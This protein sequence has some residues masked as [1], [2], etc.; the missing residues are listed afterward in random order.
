MQILIMFQWVVISIAVIPNL[1]LGLK[2][3]ALKSVYFFVI[4]IMLAFFILAIISDLSLYSLFKP[5]EI[6]KT[7]NE[8]NLLDSLEFDFS[9]IDYLVTLGD[10]FYKLI[11]FFTLFFIIRWLINYVF[12]GL[13]WEFKFKQK[14]KAKK[15]YKSIRNRL[16]G[17]FLGAIKGFILAIIFLSPFMSLFSSINNLNLEAELTYQNYSYENLKTNSGF[18]KY[19]DQIFDYAFVTEFQSGRSLNLREEFKIFFECLT[20]LRNEGYLDSNFEF[21]DSIDLKID[22]IH[23][24]LIKLKNSNLVLSLLEISSQMLIDGFFDE[25]INIEMG[26]FLTDDAK[27][28]IS[29][30]DWEKE[31]ILYTSILENTEGFETFQN[32]N[33]VIE[34]FVVDGE[35]SDENISFFSNILIKFFETE[36]FNFSGH[37]IDSYLNYETDQSEI[38]NILKEIFEDEEVDFKISNEIESFISLIHQVNEFTSISE[39]MSLINEFDLQKFYEIGYDFGSLSEQNFNDLVI[40]IK[41]LQMIDFLDKELLDALIDEYQIA[42]VIIPE[43]FDIDK[44]ID[45]TFNLLRVVSKYLYQ[46]S[47]V[48]VMNAEE[49]DFLELIV[50]NDFSSAIL[51]DGIYDSDLIVPYFSKTLELSNDSI[52]NGINLLPEELYQIEN[53]DDFWINEY[54]ATIRMLIAVLQDVTEDKELSYNNLSNMFNLEFDTILSV[55]ETLSDNELFDSKIIHNI[56][57]KFL[58]SDEFNSMI[59]EFIP[60]EMSEYFTDLS[61]NPSESLMDNDDVLG[62]IFSKDNLV[63]F[64]DAISVISIEEDK[65]ID[66]INLVTGMIDRF[67]NE[68]SSKDD[69]ERFLNSKYL[70]RLISRILTADGIINLISENSFNASIFLDK[71]PDNS[72]SEVEGITYL[73][74]NE[75]RRLIVSLKALNISDLK[76]ISFDLDTISNYSNDQIMLILESDYFYNLVSLIFLNQSLFSIPNIVIHEEG[77]YSNYINKEEIVAIVQSLS[78]LNQKEDI[79]SL[80][81]YDVKQVLSKGSITILKLI[82][83][84]VDNLTTVPIEAKDN[85]GTIKIEEI[86]QLLDFV[87]YM[88]NGNENSSLSSI[89]ISSISAS[90]DLLTEYINNYDSRLIEYLINKTILDAIEVPGS[91]INTVDYSY[92]YIIESE[93]IKLISSLNILGVESI[94]NSFSV[95]AISIGDLGN[96]IQEDSVIINK[97]ISDTVDNLTTVPIEAKDNQ[98]TIKIEEIIQ[99]LDF[100]I[101]MNNGNE[102]SSLS[103]INISSISASVDLLTEYINNYD[104]RLIEYL[105]NKTILDAIEVPGSVINTV[106][107]SYNYII[108]SELIKLISSLNI[109]GVESIENSFSVDAISIGDLGN[110]IQEDSVIINSY[111]SSLIKD[112]IEVPIGS[113]D[114]ENIIFKSELLNVYQIILII[115]D[116]NMNLVLSDAINDINSNSIDSVKMKNILDLNSLIG[117]RIVS[118]GIIETNLASSE[119]FANAGDFNY[120]ESSLDK[121]IKISEM[122]NIADALYI[123]DISNLSEIASLDYESLNALTDEE[124][125]II[126]DVSGTNTFMYYV[127]SDQ[128]VTDE[129]IFAYNL[130][131]NPDIQ[132]TN[133]RLSKQDL[134]TLILSFE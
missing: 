130:F 88:N 133:G 126:L 21:S 49:F 34:N 87:I 111:I 106:D 41:N 26:T 52:I 118:K 121:N 115:K 65:E 97:L 86:I 47:T 12:F 83:D 56:F 23:D 48:P 110:V 119:H 39:L 38:F 20:I 78:V 31:L 30:L 90:V 3:G 42:N 43:S 32:I 84:T 80:T 2:R 114:N 85:Q 134:K 14:E 108:E 98:G 70:S 64:L 9:S 92:N 28:Y 69:L 75:I 99:L 109:L 18:Q 116:N 72:K 117:Y 19:Y 112:S 8:T 71:L 100:V 53:N 125:D 124:V 45:F 127:I 5:E 103:S 122:Y 132:K 102:N 67:S 76:N 73:N 40:N 101:Y 66:I 58:S 54:N 33:D 16:T 7:I 81:L 37:F 63:D 91:V 60:A 68:N 95:D 79:E 11:V 104:S 51:Q 10:I 89:N 61:F 4:N 128:V 123:L 131:N 93:L 44:E 129:L 24:I 82:S 77:E 13:I 94:E 105:I 15:R 6:I 57:S 74:S 107:Y 22:D 35:I 1:I 120:E 59:F 96:V 25:I 36:I 27:Q 29:N 62:T 113:I 46:N 17:G 55:S 50:S